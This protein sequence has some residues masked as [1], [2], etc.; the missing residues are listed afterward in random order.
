MNT[1]HSCRTHSTAGPFFLIIGHKHYH[2]TASS[3]YVTFPRAPR[4]A[5]SSISTSQHRSRRHV[6]HIQGFIILAA[7]EAIMVIILPAPPPQKWKMK[8]L[9]LGV[10]LEQADDLWAGRWMVRVGTRERML[11]YIEFILRGKVCQ[12]GDHLKYTLLYIL[13]IHR[14]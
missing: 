14:L 9:V 8:R 2:R 1:I 13:H 3:C 10:S 5:T 12:S 11:C 7:A 4:L 6:F